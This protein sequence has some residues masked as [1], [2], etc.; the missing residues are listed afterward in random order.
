MSV[1]VGKNVSVIVQVPVENEPHIVPS[2]PG[3]Y[4][5][6]LD[7]V[8]ISDLNQNGVANEVAHVVIVDASGNPITPASV[9]DLT[10]VVTFNSGDAAKPVYLTH[11]FD[12]TPYLAQ[13][14]SIDP[15]QRVEGID[16]LG[17]DTVQAWALLL[18]E[19]GGSIKEAFKP[20]EIEQITRFKLSNDIYESFDLNANNWEAEVGSWSISNKTYMGYSGTGIGRT[21]L[22]DVNV[23]DLFA[24]FLVKHQSGSYDVGFI[25]R[26][27]NSNNFYVFG[28]NQNTDI[29]F[30]KKMVGGSYQLIQ[31]YSTPIE[32]NTY[33]N[34]KII[35]KNN[36]FRCYF[37]SNL[38]FI[39]TDNSLTSPGKIGFYLN[40]VYTQGNFDEFKLKSPPLRGINYGLI[41]SWD[42][43]GSAVKVGLDG[44]VFPEGS[45]PSPKNA[46]V[47][48]TTPF[49]AQSAKTIS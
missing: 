32:S 39:V 17:S 26:Y 48:I 22:K 21:L 41:V 37:N 36:K 24:D 20:G 2:D 18:K 30:L 34:L 27:Q 46:P 10:G 12:M 42:Q 31:Q 4:T 7:N 6:T 38:I 49:K 44:V 3:P 45:I 28:I 33:Y 40:N 14:L 15:K 5:I 47:F 11:R 13:E 16:G 29:V 1:Y 35:V 9:V 25:F 43:G 8:P 19:I 23:K